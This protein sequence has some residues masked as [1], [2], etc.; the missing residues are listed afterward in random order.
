M[1][2]NTPFFVLITGLFFIGCNQRNNEPEPDNFQ[3]ILSNPE[4]T[5]SFYRQQETEKAD[6]IYGLIFK[7]LSDEE[8]Y[9]LLEEHVEYYEKLEDNRTY[10]KANTALGK[11]WL[12]FNKIDYDSAIFCFDKAVNLYS[13]IGKKEYAAFGYWGKSVSYFYLAEYEKS[14]TANYQSLEIYES[15]K[16]SIKISQTKISIASTLIREQEYDKAFSIC[17]SVMP[18]Y[19]SIEDYNNVSYVYSLLFQIFYYQNDYQQS[20]EYAKLSLDASLKTDHLIGIGASYNNLATI[21]MEMKQWKDAIEAYEEAKRWVEKSGDKHNTVVVE[22]NIAKCYWYLGDTA[23]A[24]S[25]IHSIIDSVK[26]SKRKDILAH[27]YDLL[28]KFERDAGNYQKALHYYELQNEVKDSIFN[29]EKH[30][31]I[32][33][34]NVRYESSEKERKIEQIQAEQKA[35]YTYRIILVLILVIIVV[36]GMTVI[37]L[38]VGKNK[39]QKLT[40][41]NKQLEIEGY[42]KDLAAFAERILHKNRL[43]EELQERNDVPDSVLIENGESEEESISQ[44]YQ[45][46]ILTDA[47]WQQFKLLFDRA[48]PGMIAQLRGQWQD[49]TPAEERSFLLIKLNISNKESADMLGISLQSIKKNRYRLK[50]RFGLSEEQDLDEFVKGFG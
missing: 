37:L 12:Y 49:I 11:G 20:L 16:D 14:L 6:S 5:F 43:I 21:Y 46:K 36:S 29:D 4:T 13:K 30:K 35:G 19:V 7:T 10:F 3:D 47:D 50:K 31:I 25:I 8:K 42:K 15:L 33:E 18:Y 27:S 28:Y 9:D 32:Q 39:R 23:K 2:C 1:N 26:L 45:L 34:L 24:T 40:V 38:L 44:L 17:E 48:F 22:S 41:L